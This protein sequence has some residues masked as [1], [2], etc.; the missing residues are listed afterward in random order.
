MIVY[1]E[2][3]FST[4]Q[5]I[6]DFMNIENSSSIIRYNFFGYCDDSKISGT[7][8]YITI[9]YSFD[10]NITDELVEKIIS[11]NILEVNTT[12]EMLKDKLLN[13]KKFII[14]QSINRNAKRW[15]LTRK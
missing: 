3:S 6:I 2:K 12:Y 10:L 8:E 7:N 13:T 11:S 14:N 9:L 1:N 4:T 5:D 15:Y